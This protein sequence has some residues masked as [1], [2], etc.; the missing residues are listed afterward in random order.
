MAQWKTGLTSRLTISR[1][2]ATPSSRPPLV[3]TTCPTCSRPTIP[4]WAVSSE[5]G[6]W[7]RWTTCWQRWI[8][9]STRSYRIWW[10]AAAG[11]DN[12]TQCRTAGIPGSCSTI[13]TTSMRPACRRT[14][15]RKTWM[16]S[17]SGRRR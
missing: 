4:T 6:R 14:G 12:S 16:N 10:T 2:K 1:T 15:S 13:S 17:S 8:I 3:P 9:R 7:I 11:M 5:S